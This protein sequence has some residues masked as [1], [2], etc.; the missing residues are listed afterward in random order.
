MAI[1]KEKKFTETKTDHLKVTKNV[2]T[3][4]ERA[5][6][7]RAV[8]L[9]AALDAVSPQQKELEAL[10][11][12]LVSIA[13]ERFPGTEVVKL[14]GDEGI[15][16]FSAQ[17]QKREINDLNALIGVIKAKHGYEKLLD[18]LKVGL[19]DAEKLLTAEELAPFV[20]VTPGS[21]TLKSARVKGE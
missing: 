11:K 14:F 10:K 9:K 8:A 18:L 13:D 16:E 3:A 12:E 1:T 7:D 21:R 17:S 19:G 6:V 20:N 15:V 2:L 5:K 4:E